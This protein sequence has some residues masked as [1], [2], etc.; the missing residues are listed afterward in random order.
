MPSRAQSKILYSRLV[1]LPLLAYVLLVV[2]GSLFPWSGW[3]WPADSLIDFLWAALP[4]YITRT[5][6]TTNLLVYF[7]VGL[8]AALALRRSNSLPLTW[9]RATV[10]GAGLS[11]CME[12]G[13]NFLPWRNASNLDVL[14]NTCGSA[15][16]ALAFV[17]LHEQTPAGRGLRRWRAGLFRPG[18]DA[19]AGLALLALWGLAQLSLRLP[20]LVA[21]NWHEVWVPFWNWEQAIMQASPLAMMVYALELVS[22]TFFVLQLVRQPARRPS[23]ALLIFALLLLVKFSA[24][25]VLVRGSVLPRLLSLD[26]V[27]GTLAGLLLLG[28]LLYRERCGSAELVLMLL[29]ALVS[30]KLFYLLNSEGNVGGPLFAWQDNHIRWVNMTGFA[31]WLADIWPFAAAL[32]LIV[33]RWLLPSGRQGTKR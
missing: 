32:Y 14:M 16:G 29:A 23:A 8:L 19:D 27:G 3:Q 2:Y 6:V 5:D 18:W 30:A 25:A 33:W 21:G 13:Q 28:I 20:S 22:V 26:V 15:L 12:F 9:L 1:W 24:A 11:L 4:H 7:P 17:A 31:Y 10:F